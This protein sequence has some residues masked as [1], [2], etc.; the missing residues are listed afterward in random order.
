MAVPQ[1][2]TDIQKLP[3]VH[4]S[5]D[6]KAIKVIFHNLL[7]PLITFIYKKK[8]KMKAVVG[9]GYIYIYVSGFL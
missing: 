1:S 6:T 5:Q 9:K 3:F 7:T 2:Y 4:F 8:T